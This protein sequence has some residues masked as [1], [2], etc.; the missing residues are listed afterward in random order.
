MSDS[1]RNEINEINIKL[2]RQEEFM[3][4]AKELMKDFAKATTDIQ[5]IAKDLQDNK[6]MI[7]KFP[8][9]FRKEI[10]SYHNQP[11]SRKALKDV[12]NQHIKDY[13]AD[14]KF[15]KELSKHLESYTNKLF[16]KMLGS[17]STLIALVFAG[18]ELWKS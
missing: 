15:E 3:D 18:L 17:L 9:L 4:G 1:L 14:E 5:L 12:I 11:T 16:W 8:E 7:S 13:H 6:S 10:E 2:G